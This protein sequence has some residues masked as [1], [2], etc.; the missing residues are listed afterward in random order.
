M[1]AKLAFLVA[2]LIPAA[3]AAGDIGDSLWETFVHTRQ[4]PTTADA[5]TKAGFQAVGSCAASLGVLYAQSKDGATED[6]PLGLYFTSGG[7]IAGVQATVF[8]STKEMGKAAP[9]QLIAMGYWRPRADNSSWSVSV[10]FRAPADMCSGAAS[11]L[12]M[13]E[14]QCCYSLLLLHIAVQVIAL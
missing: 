10:S 7:Q 6:H 13:G 14:A 4:L 3:A 12:V 11:D 1:I 9:E 5:A 2:A 8:G